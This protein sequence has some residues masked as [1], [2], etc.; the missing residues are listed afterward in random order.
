MDAPGREKPPHKSTVLPKVYNASLFIVE[1]KRYTDQKMSLFFIPS[2]PF[3]A[4]S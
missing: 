4:L 2:E 3:T 1:Q